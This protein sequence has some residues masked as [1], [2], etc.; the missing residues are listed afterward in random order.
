MG[1]GVLIKLFQDGELTV[2]VLI[3]Y[4]R[5]VFVFFESK[6]STQVLLWF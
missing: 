2:K 6:A 3:S 4:V 5:F 1:M